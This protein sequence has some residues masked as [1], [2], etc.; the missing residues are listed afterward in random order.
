[1]PA[2]TNATSPKPGQN[3]KVLEQSEALIKLSVHLFKLLIIQTRV[4][5][6][7]FG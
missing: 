7:L 2:L 1:M 4:D 5:S 3:M 6:N